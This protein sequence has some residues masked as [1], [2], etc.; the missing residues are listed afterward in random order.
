M[1]LLA[2]LL[3]AGLASFGAE[4]KQKPSPK[5]ET[6]TK[7]EAQKKPSRTVKVAKRAG[8]GFVKALLHTDL[9]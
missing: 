4:P 1:R 8:V 6:M 5:Q 9:Q 7:A 2:V 3:L